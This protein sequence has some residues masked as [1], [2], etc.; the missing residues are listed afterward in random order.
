[1]VVDDNPDFLESLTAMLRVEGYLVEGRSDGEAVL[2]DIE[3][4]NPALLL[5]DL[6]MP[7]IDGFGVVQRLRN[8]PRWQDLPIVILSGADVSPDE[9]SGLT[10]HIQ[11]F[12]E[13]GQFSKELITNTVKRIIS[14][15]TEKKT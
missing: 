11:D 13:K 8:I 9:R 3:K 14:Q 7:G 2:R 15:P 10:K 1:M 5:L 4:V 12:I 6:K